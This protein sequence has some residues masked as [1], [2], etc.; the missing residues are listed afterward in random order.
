M[1][2]PSPCALHLLIQSS[3]FQCCIV[4]VEGIAFC[5][6]HRVYARY[7]YEV[8][9]PLCAKLPFTHSMI[10]VSGADICLARHGQVSVAL[11]WTRKRV[12]MLED[13]PILERIRPGQT[14]CAVI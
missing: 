1:T 14:F 6:C 13:A 10:G 11:Q 12:D 3:C 5:A 4:V 9:A 7:D 2:G 8:H